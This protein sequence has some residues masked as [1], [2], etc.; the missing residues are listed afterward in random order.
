MPDA[1]LVPLALRRPASWWQ[2]VLGAMLGTTLGGWVS[3][4]V[5]RRRPHRGQIERLPLVRPQM[6]SAVAG[7][8]E[9]HGPIGALRQ[10]TTGVPFKVFARVAGA[11]RE[12]LVPFLGWGVAARTVRFVLL[13]GTAALVGHRFPGLVARRFWL[14]TLL[15]SVGFGG[16]LWRMVRY[17]EQRA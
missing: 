15:W 10:A 7:W 11:R 5:G 17:W 13:A 3:Y 1:V 14:L 6:V 12:R 16:A 8:L 2:L 9:Q 4:R